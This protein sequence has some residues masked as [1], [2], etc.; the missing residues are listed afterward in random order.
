[1][2]ARSFVEVIPFLQSGG[3]LFLQALT[4]G[5]AG[6]FDFGLDCFSLAGAS[7]TADQTD[8]LIEEVADGGQNRR[9]NEFARRPREQRPFELLTLHR[10]LSQDL[11]FDREVDFVASASAL[12]T[13]GVAR[14]ALPV[15]RVPSFLDLVDVPT[16][17]C[18]SVLRKPLLSPPPAKLAIGNPQRLGRLF[19]GR[20]YAGEFAFDRFLEGS[21]FLVEL[22]DRVDR[23]LDKLLVLVATSFRLLSRHLILSALPPVNASQRRTMTSQ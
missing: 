6:S 9:V 14:R 12:F 5:V 16:S 3:Q 4:E 10:L 1:M 2:L 7:Q 15:V 17:R 13:V 20:C 18:A 23:G 21:L 11:L 8:E 19:V 22:F